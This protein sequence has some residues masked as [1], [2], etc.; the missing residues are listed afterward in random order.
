MIPAIHGLALAVISDQRA[1]KVDS[2]ADGLSEPHGNG[3]NPGW[4]TRV[5][6]R[7]W[8]SIAERRTPDQ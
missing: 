3:L 5:I 8:D 2:W 1:G 6:L 4:M 7:G